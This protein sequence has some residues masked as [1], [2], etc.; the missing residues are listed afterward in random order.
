MKDISLTPNKTSKA[1]KTSKTS[2]TQQEHS[3]YDVLAT[4]AVIELNEGLGLKV[5]VQ[6]GKTAPVLVFA[7]QYSKD[8]QWHYR[9]GVQTRSSYDINT[10]KTII[11]ELQALTKVEI[12]TEQLEVIQLQNEILTLT[13]K[14]QKLQK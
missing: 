3:Q 10:L 6:R 2:K 5:E 11:K 8:G 13:K 1:G 14:L 4:T 12:A 9:K 7:P